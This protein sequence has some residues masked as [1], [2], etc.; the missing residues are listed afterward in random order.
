M[1]Y[2]EKKAIADA[3]IAK[4]TGLLGWDDLSDMNSLHDCD[5]QEDIIAACDARLSEAGFPD[6]ED[7]LSFSDFWYD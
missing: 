1:L 3:Y 2:L 7:E 5:T 4:K 6:N